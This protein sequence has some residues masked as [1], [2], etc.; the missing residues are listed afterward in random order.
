MLLPAPSGREA[1][2]R[3]CESLAQRMVEPIAL[4]S[5]ETLVLGLSIGAAVFP[6]DG[7]DAAT[8]LK[9]ADAGMYATK[10]ARLRRS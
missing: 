10:Q 8:L 3:V 5:G 1:V 9:V 6:E 4:S 7:K 2:T